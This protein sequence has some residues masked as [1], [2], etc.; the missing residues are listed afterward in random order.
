MVDVEAVVDITA[1]HAPL[2]NPGFDEAGRDPTNMNTMRCYQQR[3]D[4]V[5]HL[6]L[7]NPDE[8]GIMNLNGTDV[9]CKHESDDDLLLVL[10]TEMLEPLVRWYHTVTVH[11]TGAQTLLDTMKQLCYH[12]KLTATINAVTSSCAT[13][14]ISKKTSRQCGLLSPRH[15]VIAPWNEVHINTIGS[16]TFKAAI[17]TIPKTCTF[18]ALTCIDPVNNLVELKRH[19]LNVNLPDDGDKPQPNPKLP[20]QLCHGKLSTKNGS[21]GIQNQTPSY[22][23]M[24]PSSLAANSNSKPLPTRSRPN[25]PLHITLRANPSANACT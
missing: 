2:V 22:M 13:C 24:E 18:Y 19:D 7:T 15:A 1:H 17:G 3:D 5:K 10:S 12:K 6:L 8:F 16:F 21:A 4:A 25:T 9:I 14:K 23:I 11:A 20:L